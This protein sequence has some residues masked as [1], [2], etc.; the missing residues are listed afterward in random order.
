MALEIKRLI[1]PTGDKNELLG[2]RRS[3]LFL[4]PVLM[5]M[6]VERGGGGYAMGS[7]VRGQVWELG[8]S[9]RS[10]LEG[11]RWEK[12]GVVWGTPK[13]CPPQGY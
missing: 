9:L 13:E 7:G 5:R 2:I 10:E 12:C 6:D 11:K 3:W 4:R 1:S 8:G